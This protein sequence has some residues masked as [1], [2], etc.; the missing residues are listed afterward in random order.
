[1]KEMFQSKVMILFMILMLTVGYINSIE[2][3]MESDLIE[4][5][6]II[7]NI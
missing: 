7:V 6:D 5:N 4:Q 3:K 1:M 2:V